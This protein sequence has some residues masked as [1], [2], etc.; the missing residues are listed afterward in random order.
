MGFLS[1]AIAERKS[2]SSDALWSV[3][4][5][6]GYASKAGPSVNL[7]NALKVSTAFACMKVLSQGVAQVPFKL[8]RERRADDLVKIEPA[9]NHSLYDLLTVKPN[10]WSTS[11]E[12]R[13]TLTMHAA[14]GN[15]YAFINRVNGGIY[16]LIL[17]Q[18][19]RVE[20]VQRA[21]WSITYKVTGNS[22]E[23]LEF[24]AEAIWH[25]R[26]PSWDGAL[27][28][29]V[30]QLAREALGLSIATEESHAKLHAKGV[31]PSGTY[32]VESTLDEKQYKQLKQWIENEMAGAENAGAP[33]IL[34]RGAKWLS[35]AM[36]GVDAQHLETR[37][38]ELE[39][40]CRFFGVSPF[41]VFHTDKAPTYASAEQFQIQH[42]V[43]T[44]SPWFSRIE[45]SADAH[46]LTKSERARGLYFKFM[47]AGLL[48][49]AMKDQ[50][51]FIA[52]MLGSG[53]TRPVM[54]QDEV[55]ALLELNPMG[56]D[57]GKLLPPLG[58]Q[59]APEPKPA[60]A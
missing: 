18:P 9:R 27:G 58:A 38:F 59:P 56:G 33:M 15:A 4:L 14:L 24:P 25:V 39:E 47:A 37:R 5:G 19:Q 35:Q 40:I 3:I 1:R 31:R 52:K 7:N 53:G 10:D 60:A 8:F 44:L 57:A 49:G 23:F 20:K 17:L 2:A 45:Q 43:H 26:G 11:F 13:E 22:G 55:R 41:M 42:V 50:G 36:T 34:D 51:E 21:D 46:L 48:R 54:T 12:F 29:D 28:L 16:E 30:L 6:A 32:S